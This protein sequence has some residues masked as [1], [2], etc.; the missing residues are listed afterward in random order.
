MK[1]LRRNPHLATMGRRIAGVHLE[2]GAHLLPRAGAVAAAL[3][4][5]GFSAP[6]PP[7]PGKGADFHL[8]ADELFDVPEFTRIAPTRFG[9]AALD[10]PVGAD[11]IVL[12]KLVAAH[13]GKSAG[14]IVCDLI[15]DKADA[16]GIARLARKTNAADLEHRAR[17]PP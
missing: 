10:V 11:A 5:D 15:A 7:P 3:G 8:Q 2:S 13:E 12:L 4:G 16:I 14:R 6:L 9:Q 1:P 17:P